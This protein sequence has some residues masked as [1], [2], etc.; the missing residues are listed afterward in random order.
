VELDKKFALRKVIDE[1][2]EIA[3]MKPQEAS[4]RVRIAQTLAG[5]ITKQ[6][7]DRELRWQTASTQ[8]RAVLVPQGSCFCLFS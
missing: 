5:V 8:L 4:Q 3:K 6:K 1:T 7:K 2:G